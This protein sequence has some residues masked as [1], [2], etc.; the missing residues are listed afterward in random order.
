V[1]TIARQ[2]KEQGL[3]IPLMGGDGWDSDTLIKGAGGP[4]G[5][6]EGAYFS[7]HYSKDAQTPRVRQFVDK[8][9]A[10]TGQAPE[11]L[12]AQ[13]YDAMMLLA[14]AIKRAGTT[15][16]AKV[17]DAIASTKTFPASPAT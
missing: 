6:L 5:A 12:N 2:A 7:T 14:D 11:G 13:G 10:K 17:R 1:G 15:E 4:G 9:K 16:R 3:T 8:Y